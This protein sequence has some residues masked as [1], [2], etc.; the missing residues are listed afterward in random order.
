MSWISEISPIGDRLLQIFPK[1]IRI[2][3]SFSGTYAAFAVVG[4]ETSSKNSATFSRPPLA[5]FPQ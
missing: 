3:R 4:L 5:D 1:R 2:A